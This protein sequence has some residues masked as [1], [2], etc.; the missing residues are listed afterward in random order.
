M[1]FVLSYSRMGIH[2]LKTQLSSQYISSIV[3]PTTDVKSYGSISIRVM[4]VF[5]AE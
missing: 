1:M 2:Y 5:A 4:H 3:D